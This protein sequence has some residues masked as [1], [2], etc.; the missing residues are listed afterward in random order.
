MGVVFMKYVL[1]VFNLNNIALGHLSLFNTHTVS[2][3]V[4]H[5]ALLLLNIITPPTNIIAPHT[6]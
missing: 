2:K 5:L 6:G 4:N 3:S 1:Y